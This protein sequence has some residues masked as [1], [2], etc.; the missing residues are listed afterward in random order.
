MSEKRHIAAVIT[1]VD[2]DGLE[3]F[4]AKC[5]AHGCSWESEQ[6]TSEQAQQQAL[7]HDPTFTLQDR[8]IISPPVDSPG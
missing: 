5:M 4:H 2:L 3:T 8:C 7:E 6:G 1:S